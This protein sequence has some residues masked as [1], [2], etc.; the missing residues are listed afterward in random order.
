MKK[1]KILDCKCDSNKYVKSNKHY[2]NAHFKYIINQFIN[3]SYR[4]IHS[5]RTMKQCVKFLKKTKIVKSTAVLSKWPGGLKTS[6]WLL[7]TVC[8][9][10][11][12]GS[13][14]LHLLPQPSGMHMVCRHTRGRIH[15]NSIFILKRAILLINIQLF[16]PSQF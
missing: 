6:T 13:N 11:F 5:I 3:N 7:T 10:S 8:N 1:S 15:K 14:V 2:K 4:I 9:A 12:R 16:W